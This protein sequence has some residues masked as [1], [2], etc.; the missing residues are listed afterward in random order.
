MS[1]RPGLNQ[2]SF[3]DVKHTDAKHTF[4]AVECC[5]I[6]ASLFQ[7]MEVGSSMV[8]SI[9]DKGCSVVPPTLE[10]LL[11][12]KGM[13]VEASHRPSELLVM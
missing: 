8:L 1:G 12:S 6:K 11:R 4:V 10:C 9:V 7:A 13:G 3:V 2:L 5:P